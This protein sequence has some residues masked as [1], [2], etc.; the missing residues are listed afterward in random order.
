[1]GGHGD[2]IGWTARI[3]SRGQSTDKWRRKQVEENMQKWYRVKR[4]PSDL[5]G[6]IDGGGWSVKRKRVERARG[7]GWW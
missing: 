6:Q 1:M 4:Q 5:T 7:F 3:R 2:L